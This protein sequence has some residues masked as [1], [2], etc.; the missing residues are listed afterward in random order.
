MGKDK[1][2]AKRKLNLSRKRVRALSDKELATVDGGEDS[3]KH[4][5][6]LQPT[7]VRFTQNHNQGL[8]RR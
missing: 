8:R 1:R 4:A 7:C 2:T 6:G 3:N 5:S